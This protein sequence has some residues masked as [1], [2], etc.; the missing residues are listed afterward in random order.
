M[1]MTL[2]VCY[3]RLQG[4]RYNRDMRIY[5]DTK[6]SNT[7]FERYD[8]EWL[9][10]LI[11]WRQRRRNDPIVKWKSIQSLQKRSKYDNHRWGHV[12]DL[13]CRYKRYSKMRWV[14][15]W[16]LIYYQF[17]T[18]TTITNFIQKKRNRMRIELKTKWQ[19]IWVEVDTNPSQCRWCG[20]RI[21][22]G[23]TE[24]GKSIPI[25]MLETWEYVAHFTD[26]TKA[27]SFKK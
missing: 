12:S 22:R 11:E 23:K 7:Y 9:S 20:K 27:K 3:A 17:C 14:G 1:K 4:I 6:Q 10:V 18:A 5:L 21:L 15:I 26:C 16:L 25:S 8:I 24:S 19:P 2:R 13:I